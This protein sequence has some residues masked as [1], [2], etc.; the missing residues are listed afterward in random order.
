MLKVE[1][2]LH[3][4][5]ERQSVPKAFEEAKS[6]KRKVESRIA[7]HVLGN[8]RFWNAVLNWLLTQIVWPGSFS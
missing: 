1:E 4:D 2:R 8:K 6:Q 7:A 3:M 5:M